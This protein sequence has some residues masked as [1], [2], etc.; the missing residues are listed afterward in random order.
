MVWYNLLVDF[1]ERG[2]GFKLGRVGF[3]GFVIKRG[4]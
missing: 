4:C 1:Y 2:F 3:N